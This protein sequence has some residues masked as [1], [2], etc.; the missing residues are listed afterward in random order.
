[1]VTRIGVGHDGG[2]GQDTEQ[3]ANESGHGRIKNAPADR[4][5]RKDPATLKLQM[6][7]RGNEK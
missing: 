4:L 6:V 2:G 1:M 3:K 7:A 5:I